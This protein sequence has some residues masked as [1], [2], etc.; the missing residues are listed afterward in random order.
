MTILFQQQASTMK[1][2]MPEAKSSRLT[3][4]LLAAATLMLHQPVSAQE[5]VELKPYTATYQTTS[6][7]MKLSL[8]R[9]LK[10]DANGKYT[11]TNGGKMLV[12]GFHEV[13]VFSIEDAY[14]EPSSYVYQGTGL[15][16]RRREVHFTPG[17]DTIRS[18]YKDEWY[19]LPY[20]PTTL[21]R[22]SQQEQLRLSLLNNKTPKEDAQ[23]RVADGKRIKDYSFV[24]VGDEVIDT[25]MGPVNTMHFMRPHEEPD[26]KSDTWIAPAWNYMMVRTIHIEDNKP[27]KA[28]IT[29]ASID[30][31]PVQSDQ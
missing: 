3:G 6:R 4:P 29:S 2:A 30:G 9:Q 12:A 25:P 11:L 13:A 8:D 22:L 7:G 21:D 5:Y 16:N 27:V 15:N 17:E 31:I 28:Q 10:V 14:I 1:S 18:L 19:N 26:R 23:F 20:T 24:Y